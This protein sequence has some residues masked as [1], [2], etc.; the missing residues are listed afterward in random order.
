MQGFIQLLKQTWQFCLQFKIPLLAGAVVFGVVM[1]LSQGLFVK[2]AGSGFS[3]MVSEMEAMEDRM[4]E[5][6]RRVE[7]GDEAAYE[8]MMGE[9]EGLGQGIGQSAEILVGSVLPGLFTSFLIALIVYFISHAYFLVLAVGRIRGVGALAGETVKK[10]L[11]ILG[12]EIWT[13]LRSFIWIPIVG[14]L[15][16]I[17][18]LPR[19]AFGGVFLV[20]E[21]TGVLASVSAS[22]QRTKGRWLQVFGY[23]LGLMIV[24]WIAA[25]IFAYIAFFTGPLSSWLRA[26]FSQLLFGFSV[27]YLVLL[28][29]KLFAKGAPQ[30]QPV[31][32]RAA[33]TPPPATPP[34]AAPP[35]T[36]PQQ[37]PAPPLRRSSGQA[38]PQ[39]SA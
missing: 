16:A 31:P 33:P 27:V 1:A 11:P 9:L 10:V 34:P 13:F 24:M 28:A 17:Y 14:F 5:L 7:M 18:F 20:K 30:P 21:K 35:P 19:L 23:L 12:V 8:E 15:I 2:Q 6:N 36:P 26:I 32:A 3:D 29:E 4:E 22:Y 38:P 37:P 25:A 39:Q